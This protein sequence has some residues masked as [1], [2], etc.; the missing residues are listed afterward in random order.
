MSESEQELVNHLKMS[1]GLREL[2]PSSKGSLPELGLSYLFHSTDSNWGVVVGV[3]CKVY[4]LVAILRSFLSA[5]F[6]QCLN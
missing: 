3:S 4:Q 1:R 2:L 6:A 5:A